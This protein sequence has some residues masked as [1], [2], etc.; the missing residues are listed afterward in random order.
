MRD[1]IIIGSG[2]AGLSAAIYAKRV[3]LDVVLLERADSASQVTLSE[4]IENYPGVPSISGLELIEIFRDQSASLG[5]ETESRQITGITKES[6]F[7]KLTATDGE[8]H[9]RSVIIATGAF[10]RTLGIEGEQKFTGRG[11]SYCATCDGPFFKNL[12]VAVIGGGDTAVKEALYLSKICK[13]IH[14]IHRRDCLRAEKINQRR[15]FEKENIEFHWNSVLEKVQGKIGVDSIVLKNV[16]TDEKK[17]VDVQ[18]V[19]VFVGILPS[20]GFVDVDKDKEGFIIT[21]Q[22]METSVKGIFAA[23]D[24]RSKRLRQVTTAVGDGATAAIAAEH[25]VNSL[26]TGK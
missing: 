16:K 22:E 9:A 11:V 1:L 23:G 13:K 17:K 2:P 21:D 18:G 12:E 8:L 6:D 15:I 19:F 10:P 20:T 24:C 14:L 3:E 4:L 7:F 5:V 25:Y 26:N